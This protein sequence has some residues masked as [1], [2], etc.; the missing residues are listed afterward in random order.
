MKCFEAL[1]LE[2][3]PFP[4]NPLNNRNQPNANNNNMNREEEELNIEY[5][6][7]SYIL[8]KACA[9]NFYPYLFIYWLV[10]QKGI[11]ITSIELL[12]FVLCYTY[13]SF[14]SAS[15]DVTA[16]YIKKVII[17]SVMLYFR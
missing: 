5:H 12:L 4:I 7:K 8:R 2:W 10:D 16:D 15:K 3:T 6:N 13:F 17:Y 11:F 1:Y 14:V 9:H